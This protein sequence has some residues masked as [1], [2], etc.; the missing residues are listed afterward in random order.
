MMT[1]SYK[2]YYA[3]FAGLFKVLY[4]IKIEGKENIPKEDGFLVCSNH[5][6]ATDPI[7]I[8]YAFKGHQVHYMAKK[9]LFK[10]PGLKQLITTLGAFPVDRSRADVGAIKHML[11]LL[12]SGE[13]AA[14]FPQGTRHPEEDPRGTTV[15]TGAGMISAR[16]NATVV[17]V[18]I[19]QKN[20]KHR[21]FRKSTVV[22][23]KPI[24]FEEFGYDHEVQGE[25]ARISNMIFERICKVGEESGYLK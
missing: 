6:S 10:I 18:F 1:R 9:E 19:H 7:K 22:I 15:K 5:F 4:N 2:F 25:Y 20:F 16:T 14:M 24:K 21:M 8:S 11:K 3:V 23:G 12:E 13:S 17:P